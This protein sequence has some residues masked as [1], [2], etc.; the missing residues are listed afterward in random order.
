MEKTPPS[1]VLLAFE[2]WLKREFT[3]AP[4]PE[5]RQKML[6]AWAGCWD[7]FNPKTH[8][9]RVKKKNFFFHKPTGLAWNGRPRCG[10]K[11]KRM[12]YHKNELDAVCDLPKQANSNFCWRHVKKELEHSPDDECSVSTCESRQP[13]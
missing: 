13:S 4:T 6:K 2:N 7:Q 10:V 5:E 3:F 1:G 11:V 8:D 12:H 9:N